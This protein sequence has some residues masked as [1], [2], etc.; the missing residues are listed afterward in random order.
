MVVPLGPGKFYGTSLP[1]PR[2][3][4][5]VK[6]NDERVDPPAPVLDPL[7]AWANEA[8]CKLRAEREKI[9]KKNTK[10][11]GLSPNGSKSKRVSSPSPPP[12]PIATKRRRFM[13]LIDEEEE[14]VAASPVVRRRRLVKKL[15]DDFDKVAQENKKSKEGS[16]MGLDDGSDPVASRTRR[17][18][19]DEDVTQSV[20]KV[21]EEVNK[22][23]SKGKNLKGKKGNGVSDSSPARGVRISPRLAKRG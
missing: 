1:R 8:H 5:D 12:A 14:E 3:Y 16:S 11:L 22:L 19:L 13:A 2:Y 6:F 15:G 9:A 4:T 20:M 18:I 17:L 10:I 23:N 21:V 7:L